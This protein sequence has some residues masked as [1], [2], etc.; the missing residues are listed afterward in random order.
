M[1]SAAA[2]GLHRIPEIGKCFYDGSRTHVGPQSYS[3]VEHE[4][5]CRFF[6]SR[7]HV[8][9]QSYIIIYY[10]GL[11]PPRNMIPDGFFQDFCQ[12]FYVRGN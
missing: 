10:L 8:A 4:V 3:I 1:K 6:I 7:T 2:F 9:P 5:R 12:L 11:I